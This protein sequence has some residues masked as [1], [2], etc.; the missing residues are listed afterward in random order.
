MREFVRIGSPDEIREFREGWMSRAQ[1]LADELALPYTLEVASDPFF[2]RVGQMM[3]VSQVQQSLKFE[4]LASVRRERS[5]RFRVRR[6]RGASV[7]T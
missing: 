6:G 3:A 1:Q 4:L 7:R 2:G 5:A